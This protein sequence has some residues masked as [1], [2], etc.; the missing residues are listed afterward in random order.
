MMIKR[1][2]LLGVLT[3]GFFCPLFLHVLVADAPRVE[4]IILE[5]GGPDQ[6]PGQ[7]MEQNLIELR[8]KMGP[9]D[10]D[11][12]R[13]YGYG[14]QQIRILSRSVP[15]VRQEVEHALDLAEQTG[16]PLWLHVDP[17]YAWG[18]DGEVDPQDAPRLKFW[19][20]P[21]MR[22]W[23]EFPSDGQLPT[24][25]PRLWF[26]W[27]PWCSPTPAV[28]AL[29]S[30]KMIEFACEQLAGGVLKPLSERLVR[31]KAEGREYL[32]AGINIG[33]EIHIPNYKD[34]R[35][36]GKNVTITAQ[37]P[38]HV[39]GLKMDDAIASGMQL[40]YA[41]L[42]W[43]GWTESSL[44]YEAKKSGISRDQQFLKVCF[45]AMHS[46]MAALSREC[47]DYGMS[48]DKVYTHI[49]A[50]STVRTPD[51]FMPPIWTAVNEWSTPGFTMDNKGAAK[52]DLQ[53][54]QQLVASAPGSA[55]RDFGAV[56]TYFNLNNRSYVSSADEYLSELNELFDAG[57]RVMVVYAA[58]PFKQG[59]A[60]AVAFEAIHSWMQASALR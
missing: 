50:L 54:L 56:E 1:V 20:D 32:F 53:K 59:R 49:V 24:Y 52:Y 58:F 38:A 39:R 36:N 23:A 31:W 6:G 57:A 29:G 11:S 4:Y 55:G 13:M 18:A 8:Q 5:G 12:T 7:N 2:L 21:Q 47:H 37:Q 60:P 41:S 35:K 45:V 43:M 28:P 48:R 44:R 30:P 19:E 10:P 26:N 34:R 17:F 33:W 40:G 46:Y 25:I 3:A 42:H 14:M 51:S 15:F 22:E 9:I 16:V 27:G